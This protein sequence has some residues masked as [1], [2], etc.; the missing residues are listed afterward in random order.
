MR[1]SPIRHWNTNGRIQCNDLDKKCKKSDSPKKESA[2]TY[3]G[4]SLEITATSSS[5]DGEMDQEKK[6]VAERHTYV[7]VVMS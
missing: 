7:P 6:L 2:M 5:V 4:T 3:K 1:T